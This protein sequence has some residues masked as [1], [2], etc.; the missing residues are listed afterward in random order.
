MGVV[1]GGVVVAAVRPVDVPRGTVVV[2][3][4]VGVGRADGGPE[5]DG[6]DGRDDEQH[7]AAAQHPGVELRDEEEVEPVELVH[8]HG[9]H[10]DGPADEDRQQLLQVIL[11]QAV[12]VVVTGP[13]VVVVTD[14]V[15]DGSPGQGVGVTGDAGGTGG[16]EI[17][18]VPAAFPPRGG[19]S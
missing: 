12:V 19:G 1:L 10:A 14:V 17:V 18:V 9:G 7:D 2:A 4:M 13:V 3:V 8:Q 16:T 11:A 6:A 5:R 15:H